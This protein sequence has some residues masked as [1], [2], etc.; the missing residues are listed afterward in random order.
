MLFRSLLGYK[1]LELQLSEFLNNSFDIYLDIAS[2]NLDEVILSVA[3]SESSANKIAE[4]VKL[5]YLIGMPI[6]E[7]SDS[8]PKCNN[9]LDL[10]C[11]LSWRTFANGHYPKYIHG[12]NIAVNNP[13]TWNNDSIESELSLHKGILMKNNKIRYQNSVSA[14]AH[15]G[16]LWV[17]FENIPMS[18]LFEKANYHIADYNLFWSN[19]RSNFIERMTQ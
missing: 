3:R 10:N 1:L 13:M 14:Q 6:K 4:K 8:F 7:F 16:L 15:Q 17:D 12:E 19:I 18:K 11:F 2:Q 5:A 9:P